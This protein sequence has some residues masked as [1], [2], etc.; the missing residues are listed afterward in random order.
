MLEQIKRLHRETAGTF[1]I[2]IGTLMRAW[3]F[4]GGTGQMANPQQVEEARRCVGMHLV[5]LDAQ[6]SSV[7]FTRAGVMLDLGAVGKGYAIEKAAEILR[8]AGVTS[9][10]IHGGTSTSY[11]IGKPLGQEQCDG[12]EKRA[13]SA[14]PGC[15]DPEEPRTH[16]CCPGNTPERC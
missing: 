2:T 15:L 3:G 8:E 1:D 6:Q 9:A 5:E 14:I 10:L 11:A 13:R 7:R 12:E 4:V 16:F